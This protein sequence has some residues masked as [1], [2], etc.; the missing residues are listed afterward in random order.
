[1]LLLELQLLYREQEFRLEIL[2]KQVQPTE[3][4]RAEAKAHEAD[5]MFY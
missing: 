4:H 2:L 3:R 1:M 5:T